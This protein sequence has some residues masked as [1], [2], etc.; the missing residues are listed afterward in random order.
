MKRIIPLLIMLILCI[1]AAFSDESNSKQGDQ[2]DDRTYSYSMNGAGD[3]Y[4][5]IGLMGFFPLNFG[6]QLYIGG[7]AQLGYHRFLTSWLAVGGDVMA[8]YNPT[9]GSN[10]FYS[11]PITAG[12]TFQ[13]TIW[14]LEFPISLN[15]GIAV[16]TCQNRKYF[17]GFI[18][19][20]EAG[21]FYRFSE[22]WSFGLDCDF[23]YMPEWYSDHPEYNDY[24]LFITAAVAAR[25]HF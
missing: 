7:A 13:P 5:Q 23:I 12:V 16:E 20:P 2:Y 17:P 6:D 24:G 10:V 15:A 9:L 21:V 22:S 8:T 18:L 11:V 3:Q 19:K 1:P 4:I 25:Y 14:K